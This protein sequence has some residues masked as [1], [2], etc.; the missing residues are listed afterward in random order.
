ML[1]NSNLLYTCRSLTLPIHDL[2]KSLLFYFSWL[3]LFRTTYDYS[4]HIFVWAWVCVCAN[5]QNCYWFCT[6]GHV[7]VQA[8]CMVCAGVSWKKCSEYIRFSLD[9]YNRQKWWC[10][11]IV[12]SK[13]KSQMCFFLVQALLLTVTGN[14]FIR[15]QS[16]TQVSTSNIEIAH[17]RTYIQWLWL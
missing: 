15:Q 3:A 7:G 17:L 14:L 12:L 6:T 1:K 13:K 2:L 11:Y 10:W 16:P 8:M 4:V 5:V 9:S